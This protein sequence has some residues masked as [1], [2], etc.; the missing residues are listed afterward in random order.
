MYNIYE[1]K[2]KMDELN[3]FIKAQEKYYQIALQEIKNGH[4]QTHWIWFIFPQLKELG[5][6]DTAL[7]YGIKG[8]IEAKQYLKNEYLK[9]NLIEISENLLKINKNIE[10]IV[11]YPDNLKIKSSMTLFHIAGPNINT[12]KKVIDKFYNQELDNQTISIINN[13]K[14]LLTKKQG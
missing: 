5:Q 11:N 1:R 7:Y 9:H 13:H 14:I 12:F 3:R 4:K 6:S 10:E 2:L 8:L